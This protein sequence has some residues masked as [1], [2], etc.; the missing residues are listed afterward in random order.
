VSLI[1]DVHEIGHHGWVHEVLSR[2]S[3]QQERSVIERAVEAL[4]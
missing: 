2:L 1:A 4:E 3:E